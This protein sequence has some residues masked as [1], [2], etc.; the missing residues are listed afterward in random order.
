MKKL[1]T[2]IMLCVTM[3]TFSQSIEK[4][5]NFSSITTTEGDSIVTINP[6]DV[7]NLS[8]GK[9]NYSLVD[10]DS[11]QASGNYIHQNNLLIFNYNQP[12]DTVRYYNVVELTE[13]GL[14]LSEK[15]MLYKFTTEPLL[16]SE[17]AAEEVQQKASEII[18]SQGFSFHSLWRGAL[19]MV[20]LLI[21]AFLF[22][23][24]R[25]AI[26]WKIVGLGLA[27]QLLIAVGVLKIPFV[28][29]AFELVGSLFVSVLDFTRAGSEFLF[30][31]LVADMDSFGFIFAFQ[32][33]P[34]IIFFSALTSLL[35]YLGVIQFIVKIFAMVLSKILKISG[36]ESLS[37]AGNI[38]LGQTEAPLLIK[39]YLEKMNRS[40]I[41]L[42]MI[43]GMATVAGAVLA[44]YI[45]FLGGDDEALRL[46]YAKHLLAA[47]VMAAPGAIIISKILYPQTEE[48]NTDVQV[49]SEKIGSNI[50]DAIANGTTEGLQLAMNVAA[51]LL[52]FIA[53]IAMIN[54]GLNLIGRI[55]T[56]NDV[57]ASNTPY[58][59]LSLEFILGYVFA[60]LMWLIGVAKEDMA[61]MGQL[62]GVKLAASEFVGYIQLADLKNAASAT[63]LTYNKSIIMATYMLCGFANFA[64]IGI[65]I[66]GI[67]S[68]APGQRKNLSEFGMKALIGGT[69]ASLMSATI[70]GMIIG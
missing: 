7:L 2:F 49:S 14:T 12:N 66:G 25:R 11:L 21:L 31:G 30:S 46:L 63:H 5:W 54:G 20:S 37:V 50:L 22:S 64:S 23:A 42:V 4:K 27:F 26:D 3:I 33:L 65:Q 57:V 40:E 8:E 68:L 9:F 28:Q 34:T 15:N 55:T 17:V 45:G 61:L 1:F 67:G 18:P 39:A 19:G 53:F 62:L 51:M 43:G 52:V 56:L 29:K 58:E 35:F 60:P 36:A 48:V 41:L 70:A 6:A 44:A 69:I 13:D 59:A 16:V 10:K 47:S 24:N 38:F 32:V